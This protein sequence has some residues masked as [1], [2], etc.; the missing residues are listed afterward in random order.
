[1]RFAGQ[2]P[3]YQ[4][5]FTLLEVMVALAILAVVA[6]AASQTSRSYTLSVGNMETRTQAYFIAQNTLAD[7]RIH[8]TWL[9]SEQTKQVEANGQQ[10]QITITP[11]DTDL[12]TLKKV[13]IGVAPMSDSKASHNIV[14]FEGTLQKPAENTGGVQ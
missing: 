12:P 13:S 6:V 2:S 3:A 1:M 7:L 14:T 9:T 10:W 5:G 4:N 8:S 11:Q